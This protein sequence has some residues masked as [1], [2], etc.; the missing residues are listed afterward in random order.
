MKIPYQNHVSNKPD[1]YID[2]EAITIDHIGSDNY[3][4]IEY[5]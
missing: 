5:L 2:F 3:W 1:M 4:V